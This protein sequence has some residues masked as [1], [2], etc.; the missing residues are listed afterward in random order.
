LAGIADIIEWGCSA[1]AN[2]NETGC[3]AQMGIFAT[4]RRA[5]AASVISGK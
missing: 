1:A 4:I 3:W 5:P 2:G